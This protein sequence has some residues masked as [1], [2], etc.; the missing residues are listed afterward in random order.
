M[1]D[2]DWEEDPVG[3]NEIS[4]EDVKTY[5]TLKRATQPLTAAAIAPEVS[6][7][8][9]S[10]SRAGRSAVRTMVEAGVVEALPTYPPMYRL[11][12]M[13]SIPAEGQKLVELFEQA[14]GWFGL[15]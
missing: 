5:L 2:E 14:I 6:K 8:S 13:D 15:D 11:K 3:K 1:D 7:T 10:R 12:D 4:Q 9:G